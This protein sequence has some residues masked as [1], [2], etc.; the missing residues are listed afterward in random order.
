MEISSEWTIQRGHYF[1]QHLELV[2]APQFSH[3]GVYGL[4]TMLSLS[5]YRTIIPPLY[6]NNRSIKCSYLLDNTYHA[7]LRTKEH[8]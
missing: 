1:I 6:H 4:L 2:H 3:Q 8:H 7:K 5:L